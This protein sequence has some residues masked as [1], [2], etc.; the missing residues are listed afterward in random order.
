MYI[1]VLLVLSLV[2]SA[3]M[4]PAIENIEKIDRLSERECLLL[5]KKN[6]RLI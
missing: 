4:A 2:L 1:N 6:S 3:L 5:A